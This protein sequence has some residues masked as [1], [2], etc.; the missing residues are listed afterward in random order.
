MPLFNP[1]SR[2]S[3]RA[4]ITLLVLA[5][6]VE[7]VL[8]VLLRPFPGAAGEGF[9]VAQA[10]ANGRGFADAYWSGQGPTAHLLPVSPL[11][12]GGVYAVFGVR[13]WPAEFLLGC[14]SIGLTLS[15]YLILFHAFGRLGT[16]V[17]ARLCA[18]AFGFLV[19][20]Y[21]TE[22]VVDFRIWEGG[23]AV[24]LSAL[25]LDRLLVLQSGKELRMPVIAWMALLAALLFFVHPLI[26]IS[27]YACAALVCFRHLRGAQLV[28][29]AGVATLALALFV[30]PWVIRNTLVM[31]EPILLRSNAGLELALANYPG[32]VDPVDYNGEYLRRLREI[33]P[34]ASQQAREKLT[35]AGGEI[36]YARQ[37]GDEAWRWISANPG[38]T[39]RLAL[40][41]LRQIFVPEPWQFIGFRSG[42]FATPRAML[43]GAVG[44]LGLFG[45]GLAL[46]QRR[47]NWIFPTL[48]I[49]IPA[50]TYCLFQPIPRYSYLFYPLLVFCAADGVASIA[51]RWLRR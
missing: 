9:D 39:M 10:L 44:V 37:L 29:A 40:R 8:F 47:V 51:S 48:L 31:G 28:G 15:A 14:W 20:I 11:I 3:T 18:L 7:R 25:F 49:A 23:L 30:V 27:A 5:A 12:A 33:H 26:G 36:R 1:L 17:W 45:L 42:T 50:L 34:R 38:T 19:P 22:E 21:I 24:F 13:S 4:I 46:V 32:A 16:P 35:M 41:H 2:L 43:A 6:I